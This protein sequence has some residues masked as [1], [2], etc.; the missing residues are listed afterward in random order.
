MERT[1]LWYSS[2]AAACRP[3][4]N[5]AW[6]IMQSPYLWNLRKIADGSH[7][8]PA[9][10]QSLGHLLCPASLH[11]CQPLYTCSRYSHSIYLSLLTAISC[12]ICVHALTALLAVFHKHHLSSSPWSLRQLA[13]RE[14]KFYENLTYDHIKLQC[15]KYTQLQIAH[16]CTQTQLHT[17]I[18]IIALQMFVNLLFHVYQ[19]IHYA[20]L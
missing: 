11:I 3:S 10:K 5:T 6:I 19:N 13:V 4:L 9:V 7:H 14:I 18:L 15:Q 17:T 20:R 12:T 8:T 2:S 16:N 1:I